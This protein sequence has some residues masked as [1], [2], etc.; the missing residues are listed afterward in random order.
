N[1]L[2]STARLLSELWAETRLRRCAVV[3]ST[4]WLV[5]AIALSLLPPLVMRTLGGAETVVTIHLAIF[6]VAIGI[7]SA[8]ASWLSAGRIIL[9]P[10]AVGA[11]L[12]GLFS[13]DLGLALLRLPTA[14]AAPL[15][16]S[17]F[18]SRPIA[19]RA[20]IDLGLVAIA[21][22]LMIVPSFAAIQAWA[23]PERRA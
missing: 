5:G 2:G 7:G 16:P 6:A 23:A 12:V 20:A 19:W 21:G 3:T 10:T 9:W 22:G 14:D 17:A 1:I 15:A 8:L 18:F 11:L 4:F 13:L